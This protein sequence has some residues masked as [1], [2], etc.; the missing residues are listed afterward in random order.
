MI[1]AKVHIDNPDEN[2][3]LGVE[4][5]VSILAAQTRDTLRV[6]QMRSI[7]EMTACSAMGWKMV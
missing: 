5:K 3:F 7:L 6:L 4:A 2:I 1:G